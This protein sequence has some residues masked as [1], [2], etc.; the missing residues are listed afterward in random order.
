MCRLSRFVGCEERVAYGDSTI[1]VETDLRDFNTGAAS[2]QPGDR[3]T[4]NGRIDDDF[5]ESRKIEASNVFVERL[6]TTYHPGAP[7]TT[8]PQGDTTGTPADTMRADDGQDSWA[9]VWLPMVE[10]RTVL[11]GT[12]V[13]VGDEEFTLAAGTGT[14]EVEVDEMTN[15]PLDDD[16][17]HRIREGDRVRVWGELDYELFEGDSFDATS[18]VTLRANGKSE[19]S[20]PYP[21]R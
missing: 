18:V 6:G 8:R 9:I 3:V 17:Y 5:L 19:M 7:D 1:T 16:G 11:E 10:S 21:G 4:V 15:N 2:L 12:V 14:I 20:H 13:K